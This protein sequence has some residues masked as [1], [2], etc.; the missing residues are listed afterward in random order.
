MERKIKVVPHHKKWLRPLGVVL[1]FFVFV[2]FA[3]LGGYLVYDYLENKKY[4]VEVPAT[5]VEI[6]TTEKTEFDEDE[7]WETTVTHDVYVDY[8]VKGVKYEH[9]KLNFYD[10]T[11]EE[12]K[13]ITVMYDA[14][15]PAKLIT[16]GSFY[17][18]IFVCAVSI[19]PLGFSIYEAIYHKAKKKYTQ[20]LL[21]KGVKVRAV[22][23]EITNEYSDRDLRRMQENPFTARRR[24][25]IIYMISKFEEETFYLAI[26]KNNELYPGCTV[27]V[28]IDPAGKAAK[29]FGKYYY[30]DLESV[31]TGEPLANSN[32]NSEK[33]LL[34]NTVESPF[35]TVKTAT[36]DN[37]SFEDDKTGFDGNAVLKNDNDDD[38]NFNGGGFGQ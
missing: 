26:E 18:A 7:G 21:T 25:R 36:F 8:E 5:I 24:R 2:L 37:G 28:Y 9:V 12:G 29:K 15:N 20:F 34:G 30:V 3:G 6:I 27:D 4:Y 17:L 16:E 23:T 14:R 1:L 31:R 33:D 19:I 32:F 10:A 38:N 13:E 22:V 11:M 35:Q